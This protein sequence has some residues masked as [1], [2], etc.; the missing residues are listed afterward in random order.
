MTEWLLGLHNMLTSKKKTVSLLL[1]HSLSVL[2]LK[3]VQSLEAN[4]Y[5][6]RRRQVHFYDRKWWDVLLYSVLESEWEQRQ[7]EQDEKQ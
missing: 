4:Q 7:V 5:D 6:F 1:E 2:L 3:S